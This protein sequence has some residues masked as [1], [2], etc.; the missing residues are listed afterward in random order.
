M[1]SKTKKKGKGKTSNKYSDTVSKQNKVNS[2]TKKK[3]I[4]KNSNSKYSY[5]IDKLNKL[6]KQK[7]RT[8]SSKQTRLTNII[9]NK[10][11]DKN[12][13]IWNEFTN[14]FN[15]NYHYILNNCNS[16]LDYKGDYISPI[17]YYRISDAIDLNISILRNIKS[18][19]MSLFRIDN[20]EVISSKI[21][22][23]CQNNYNKNPNNN[24]CYCCG[25]KVLVNQS[26]SCDH[27]IP[28]LTMLTIV[29]NESINDNLFFIH[30]S[31][32]LKKG[33]MDLYTLFYN[34]GG[35]LFTTIKNKKKLIENQ[36]K[37]RE[38]IGN[39]IRKIKF[40][41]ETEIKRKISRL[42]A[43]NKHIQAI[44]DELDLLT[45]T[46]QDNLFIEAIQQMNEDYK[47]GSDIVKTSQILYDIAEGKRK[48]KIKKTKRKK[49]KRKKS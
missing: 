42:S 7:N 35:S 20:D 46:G 30:S 3:I 13:T 21:K 4:V 14:I 2:V 26:N 1:K 47:S 19:F 29:S 37:C 12:S 39:Y 24:I 41:S 28:I 49:T 6:L 5:R 8:Q 9:V 15:S 16:L 27:L 48:T 38:I 36:K 10:K 45:R 23:A 40:N 44:K 33:D 11:P 32:N 34:A 17:E 31:C 18:D 22:T 25:K 43:I